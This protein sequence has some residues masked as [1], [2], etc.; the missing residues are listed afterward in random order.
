MI[1]SRLTIMIAISLFGV[2]FHVIVDLI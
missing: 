2:P 1:L